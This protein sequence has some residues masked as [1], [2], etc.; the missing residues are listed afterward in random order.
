MIVKQKKM[1][2]R[3][4]Y[5][6]NLDTIYASA[7]SIGLSAIKTIRISGNETKKIFKALAKKRLPKARYCKLINLYDIKNSSVIDKAIVVWF[8]APKTYTGENML[9]I[10]IH[11]GNSVLEHLVENLLL[12]IR[13][14]EPG[15]AVETLRGELVGVL[16][17]TGTPSCTC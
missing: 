12:E 2:K 5:K 14:P 10:N 6:I 17:V 11:G 9:E 13:T 4:K 16:R 8:P 1:D 15:A 7:S 3:L